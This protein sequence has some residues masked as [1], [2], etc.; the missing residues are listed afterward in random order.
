MEIAT[1]YGP[2]RRPYEYEAYSLS[3]IESVEIPAVPGIYIFAKRI[4]DL[5]EPVA[6]RAAIGS[7]GITSGNIRSARR[8]ICSWEPIY[9]GQSQNLQKRGLKNYDKDTM[10]CINKHGS[11]HLL[12]RES[13]AIESV[14]EGE[15]RHLIRRHNPPCNIQHRRFHLA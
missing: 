14:R 2:D 13:S 4:P 7:L 15:E 3:I 1:F 8:A 6:R 5:R 12:F 9:I 11:S 10:R